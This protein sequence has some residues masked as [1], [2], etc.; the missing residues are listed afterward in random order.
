MA[1]TPRSTNGSSTPASRAE[2]SA[3]GMRRAT[4]S[5]APLTPIRARIT[6]LSS[7]APTTS[8]GVKRLPSAIKTASPGVFQ[9]RMIGAL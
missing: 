6:P 2:A 9:P 3:A 1:A 4:A 8:L 5:N 7:S